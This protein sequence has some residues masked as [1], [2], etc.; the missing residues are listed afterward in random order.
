MF[1][2]VVYFTPRECRGMWNLKQRTMIYL[3]FQLNGV[4]Q[5]ITSTI[6]DKAYLHSLRFVYNLYIKAFNSYKITFFIVGA[7]NR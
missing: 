5:S 4:L 2:G 1:V 6:L 7:R 3:L